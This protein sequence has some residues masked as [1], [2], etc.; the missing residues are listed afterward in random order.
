MSKLSQEV[1]VL[2]YLNE[3][4]ER[5]KLVTVGEIAEELEVSQ[6]QARRYLEDLSN[7]LELPLRITLGRNGGYRLEK[8][9]GKGLALTDNIALAVS[10][11]MRRNER[12]EKV[13]AELPNYVITDCIDGDNYLDEETL[14]KLELIHQAIVKEKELSLHYKNY[15]NAFLIQPYRVVLTNHAYYLYLVNKANDQLEKFD[16]HDIKDIEMGSSFLADQKILRE[17]KEHL[18]RY[19]IKNG[20]NAKITTLRVKCRDLDALHIF[21]RYFENKGKMDEE[22]LIYE[23]VGNSENEL[24]YPLFRISTKIYEFLDDEFK[25]K[26]LDYLK[27]QIKSIEGK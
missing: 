24:Y 25:K 9:L 27:N 22:S 18:S 3:R 21:D 8:P 10:L 20:K 19:G 5:Q 16:I 14:D 4:S 1:R 11:A 13:L 23:V 15:E 12:I 17:I 7:I 6:R 2:L 26:Y